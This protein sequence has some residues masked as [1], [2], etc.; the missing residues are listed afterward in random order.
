MHYSEAKLIHDEAIKQLVD[1]IE[2]GNGD[3]L[4]E[5]IANLP[6]IDR[7]MKKEASNG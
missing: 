3:N 2:N 4:G 6:D 7:L 5:R 1:D